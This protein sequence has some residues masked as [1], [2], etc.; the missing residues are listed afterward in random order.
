MRHISFL[1]ALA[2]LAAALPLKKGRTWAWRVTTP[3]AGSVGWITA[4]V[5]DSTRHDSGA[6]WR[7]Q[8]R[9][10]ASGTQDTAKLLAY[11]DGRQNW[12]SLSGLLP[13]DPTP[14]TPKDSIRLANPLI[15]TITWPWGGGFCGVRTNLQGVGWSSWSS[16]LSAPAS[17]GWRVY[18]CEVAPA[19][20]ETRFPMENWN[21]ETD[22]VRGQLLPDFDWLLVEK[23]GAAFSTAANAH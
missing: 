17:D 22:Y 3:S 13:W 20:S 9:D 6:V 16:R 21:P 14:Y 12:I 7:L 18:S 15:D 5:L 23:D 10:S 11:K 4:K 1:L 8:V 2:S 19:S